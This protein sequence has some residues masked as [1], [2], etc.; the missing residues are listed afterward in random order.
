MLGREQPLLLVVAGYRAACIREQLPHG[1]APVL[2][3]IGGGVGHRRE[4]PIGEDRVVALRGRVRGRDDDAAVCRELAKEWKAG[5]RGV[6]DDQSPRHLAKQLGPFRG[7]QIRAHQVELR[8]GRVDR[9]VSQQEDEDDI[10]AR[11]ARLDALDRLGDVRPG[12]GARRIAAD[13][14]QQSDVVIGEAQLPQRAGGL[15]FP[16]A[17]CRGELIAACSAGDDQGKS[18]LG[19]RRRRAEQHHERE[20]AAADHF[21]PH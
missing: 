20:G 12:A 19:S 4:E 2:V 1:Y 21:N 11:D 10:G 6:D 9:A 13:A 18:I 7:G 17:E 16:G 15:L 8:A 5:A 3:Q 14:G